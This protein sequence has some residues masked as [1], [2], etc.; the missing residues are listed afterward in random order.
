MK[1]VLYAVSQLS[2]GLYCRK[3]TICSATVVMEAFMGTRGREIV[4]DQ[5]GMVHELINRAL[6]DE[7]LD[8]ISRVVDGIPA[9][10]IL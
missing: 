6:A 8:R 9:G 10:N 5:I 3:D 4:G 2:G 7:Q 1:I